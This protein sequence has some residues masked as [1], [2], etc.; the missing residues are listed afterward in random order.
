MLAYNVTLD[1]WDPVIVDVTI[2]INVH[3]IDLIRSNY[4]IRNNN[5]NNAHL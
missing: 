2:Y 4:T 5:N 1:T 3:N